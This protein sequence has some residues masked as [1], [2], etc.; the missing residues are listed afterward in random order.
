MC[1]HLTLC[2]IA[3]TRYP[4][5]QPRDTF[6]ARSHLARVLVDGSLK[7]YLK[8]LYKISHWDRLG[9]HYFCFVERSIGRRIYASYLVKNS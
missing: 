1:L 9:S 5:R 6:E 8:M 4:Q 7:E 2:Q 3:Q